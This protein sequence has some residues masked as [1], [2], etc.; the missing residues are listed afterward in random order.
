MFKNRVLA[1]IIITYTITI[2]YSLLYFI[3]PYNIYKNRFVTLIITSFYMFIPLIS[4][5]ILQKFIYK[6]ELKKIGFNFKWTWWYLFP[7]II[8]IIWNLLSFFIALLFPDISFS[9]DMS[10]MMGRYEKNFTAD[11]IKLMKEQIDKVPPVIFFIGTLLQ[12]II[13]GT[14]FNAIFAFGEESGWRGFLLSN[15]KSKGFY[16][17]S[18]ITGL[19]WGIWHFPVIIQGHN[20]PEH[21]TIGVFM[22]ILWTI[23]LSPFF[24]FIVYKTKTVLSASIMHGVLNASYGLSIMYLKGGNDLTAGLTGISGIVALI[25]SNIILFLYIKY[26]DNGILDKNYEVFS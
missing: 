25:I 23:L 14:T 15:L 12:I 5:V 3:F 18:L 7:V 1:F 4:S 8:P 22:M 6:E 24:T 9:P 20:Y 17:S 21:R 13:F 16:Y 19:I 10:G 26:F 2:L 11:Q